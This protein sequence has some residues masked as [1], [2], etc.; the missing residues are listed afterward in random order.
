MVNFIIYISIGLIIF[1]YSFFYPQINV[2]CKKPILKIINNILKTGI[3]FFIITFT[4][5]SAVIYSKS[6][7]EPKEKPD[8]LIVLGAGLIGDK[9]TLPLQNRLNAAAEY[10]FENPSVIIIVSGGQ[11]S[12]ETVTEAY[13]MK[14]YLI[15]LGVLEDKI[16]EEGLST[17]TV[18][19]LKFSKDILDNY[20]EN[21][22]YSIVYVT[23]GTHVFRSGLISNQMGL[24]SESIGAKNQPYL[25]VNQYLYEYFALIKY[26]I[27][28]YK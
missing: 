22:N 19:N 12:N 4:L 16:I 10:Y 14:K 17:R 21:D 1:L 18:E 24:N 27:L 8:A 23:N 13:A 6:I 26:F 25:A 7:T 2:L 15:S 20:F 5:L 3:V 28:D 9:I 11:G